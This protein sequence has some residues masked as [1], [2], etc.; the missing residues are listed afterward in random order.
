MASKDVLKEG[1]RSPQG[2]RKHLF[3]RESDLPTDAGEQRSAVLR[4][5]RQLGR[6]AEALPGGASPPPPPFS[7]PEKSQRSQAFPVP[8][9]EG[10]CGPPAAPL[11]GAMAVLNPLDS[12]AAESRTGKAATRGANGRGVGSHWARW[13]PSWEL[14]QEVCS[15]GFCSSG[16]TSPPPP[17]P[18]P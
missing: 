18:T 13:K 7:G 2:A 6:L 4:V 11:R 16:L 15:L 10:R 3:S 9:R 14:P 5:G 1:T 8:R 12:E 17:P